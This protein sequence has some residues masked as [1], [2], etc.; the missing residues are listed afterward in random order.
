MKKKQIDKSKKKI[1]REMAAE[2]EKNARGDAS[3]PET[4]SEKKNKKTGTGKT[5][6]QK[7][8]RP[9]PLAVLLQFLK[10]LLIRVPL[11]IIILIAIVLG[12]IKIYMTPDRVQQLAVSSFNRMSYGTL[13][14]KVK[15]FTPYGGFV[16]D[17]ILIKNGPE[18][19]NST[20]VSIDR[21]VLKYHLFRLFTGSVRFS[22]IGIYRPRVYLSEKGGVWNAARLMKPSKKKPETKEEPE[23]EEKDA[24]PSPEEI[25]LPISV[26]FFL[27]FVLD[28]LRVYVNSSQFK[29]RMEGLTFT[30]DIEVPP[31]STI[32]LSPKAV[33]LI[34]TMSIQLNP[35][36]KMKLAYFSP[37]ID[38]TPPLVLT[39]K[40][41][42]QNKKDS[43]P[44][45]NSHFKFGTYKSPVRFKKKYLAPL[46]F[47]VSYNMFYDPLKDH[48]DLEYLKISFKGK[49]WL[50]LGGS[51]SAVTKTPY[52]NLSMKESRIVTGDLYP[53][54]VTFTGDRRTRFSGDLSLYPLSI[55]GTPNDMKV[56]G[57]LQFRQLYLKT[58]G[59]EARIPRID[60][61]YD[62]KMK[63][64]FMD[65]SADLAMPGFRYVLEGSKS[66][67]NSLYL[68]ARASTYDN[69]ARAELHSLKLRYY[70]PLL[71]K[72]ALSLT[73]KGK[74][75][76]G[77]TIRGS[78]TIKD[79]TF[80]KKPLVAMVSERLQKSLKGIPLKQPATLS[81]MTYFTLGKAVAGATMTLRA[82]VPD[83]DLND[84][85]LKAKAAHY[86][87]KKKAVINYLTLTS[88]AYN[89]NLTTKGWVDL[90]RAPLADSDL[91][92]S[93]SADYPKKKILYADYAIK[94]KFAFN[95]GMKGNLKNG[96]V[97]GTILFDDF[98]ISSKKEK[99]HVKGFNLAFPFH[100]PFAARKQG[101]SLIAVEKSQLIDNDAFREKPNFTIRSIAFKHIKRDLKIEYMKDF[102]ACMVFKNNVFSI[103]NMKAYILDGSLYSRQILF[104]LADLKPDNMEYRLALDLTNVDIAKLDN[105]Y[106]GKKTRDAELSLNANFSGR[107]VNVAR[108]LTAN[109]YVNIHKV[110]EKFANRLMKGL[111]TT[112]G[113]SKLGGLTQFVVDN[114][115]SVR[116]FNFNLSKGLVYTTV[117]FKPGVLSAI[118]TIDKNRVSFDRIP[119]QEYLRKV[120]EEK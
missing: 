55:T 84:L 47:L 56:K 5:K 63:G 36:E 104:N 98:N 48:L 118:A 37:D 80:D 62:L 87:I 66:Q 53:Y 110:G 88:R 9:L 13:S 15:K 113:K 81:M 44:A 8:K 51:I 25:S 41:V 24:G 91:S 61:A 71:K 95:A 20:F 16:I 107:G 115:M 67:A 30:T 21:L 40:L 92:I 54:F 50:N 106:T 86:P 72:N 102:E 2:E 14:M 52:I 111:S 6:S 32:P 58:P 49:N 19:K 34:K 108:Q 39:W 101:A 33:S 1:I 120:R 109:G 82:R 27:K 64:S 70:N 78:V 79:L 100:Y 112:K 89:L 45:F 10:T 60:L 43:N 65:V 42:F 3:A 90:A 17:D 74:A 69:V 12:G 105:A 94:G 4:T 59:T 38:A 23:P 85:T 76:L 93:L 99:M 114:S 68:S 75:S 103:A 83:Y 57:A 97:R 73:M 7:K 119:I 96:T 18:F 11:T 22:E 117:L 46:N 35:D 77:N 28:D 29:T 26:D 31:C 116:S